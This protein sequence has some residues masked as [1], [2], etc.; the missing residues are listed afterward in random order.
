[1]RSWVGC[2]ATRSKRDR[3]YSELYALIVTG[4]VVVLQ[5]AEDAGA[6]QPNEGFGVIQT[7]VEHHHD[8]LEGLDDEVVRIREDIRRLYD[9]QDGRD[10]YAALGVA[11]GATPDDITEAFRER[12]STYHTD[13]FRG[14]ELGSDLEL[15]QRVLARW[16]EA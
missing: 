15:L 11:I 5:A 2:G 9:E 6:Q 3:V 7:S 14:M 12:F 13:R 4:Q 10:H 8:S 1:M 16:G